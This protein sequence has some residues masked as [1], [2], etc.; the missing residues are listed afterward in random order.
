MLQHMVGL[1][2][3][4]VVIAATVDQD[5]VLPV[6]QAL[7]LTVIIVVHFLSYATLCTGCV[8]IHELKVHQ[9]QRCLCRF[10]P[11][12]HHVEYRR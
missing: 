11:T 6:M 3:L 1:V 8:E 12:H 5:V 2:V 10:T 9:L 4:F 7:C